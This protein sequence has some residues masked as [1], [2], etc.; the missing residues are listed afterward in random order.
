[1]HGKVLFHGHISLH[2]QQPARKLDLMEDSFHTKLSVWLGRELA[3]LE[4]PLP[5][6]VNLGPDDSVS[7]ASAPCVSVSLIYCR[8]LNT[9]HSRSSTS[10]WL[11]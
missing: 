8:L 7:N 10:P 4:V 11:T 5:C 9:D 6:T 2:S 1:L 3:R